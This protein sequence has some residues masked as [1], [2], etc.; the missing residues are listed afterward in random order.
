MVGPDHDPKIFGAALGRPDIY[1]RLEKGEHMTHFYDSKTRDLDQSFIRQAFA[2]PV[3]SRDDEIA[4]ISAWLDHQDEGALHRLISAH[5]RLAISLATKFRNY[6]LPM[7]DLIQEGVLG[8]ME[9]AKRFDRSHQ[10]RFATYATW[11]IRAQMQDYIL[12]NW[13]IVRTGTTSAQKALFF[14]L[15]R[16][17]ARIDNAARHQ[18]YLDDTA[19]AEIAQKLHVSVK[20]VQSME[21]RLN[22]GD[23]SLN[24]VMGPEGD[25]EY[26]ALLPDSRPNPE[27]IVISMKDAKVRSQWLAN[28]LSTLTDREKTIIQKRHLA[29]RAL[30]LEDLG[31]TLGV[32]KERVRQLEHRA[33]EKMKSHLAS[34]V[35]ERADLFG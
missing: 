15:R 16:L 13:S 9:A 18:E 20:D 26:I 11:W 19:T 12:R 6:G 7:N 27:D 23:L 5:H 14:N 30:T 2:E 25:D 28:A 32:S 34:N 29:P 21:Q 33:L 4:L 35:L 1:S 24:A 8:L 31:I 17:R 10:V 22:G 3:L